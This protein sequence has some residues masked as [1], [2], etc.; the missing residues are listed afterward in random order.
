MTFKEL[1]GA[2]PIGYLASWR[3]DVA[4]AE[5]EA[6]QQVKSVATLCGFSSPAAFS[7]A[8]SKKFGAPPKQARVEMLRLES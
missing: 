6:G 8:F 4:R 2:T 1:V 3:L 7:R 5:L